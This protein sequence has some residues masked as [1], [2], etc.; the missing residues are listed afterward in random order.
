[1]VVGA[2]H[3]K[4]ISILLEDENKINLSS[5][6]NIPASSSIVKFIG[7]S[8][9][10]IIIGSLFYIGFTK[11]IQTVGDN[12]VFWI[13]A[14]GILSALGTLIAK[15]HIIT[16]AAAFFAA[17]FTSLTPVI[18]AGYVA[19]FVQMYVAPPIVKEFE[20]V[21]TDMKKLKSW[22]KN[23]LLRILLVFL[24]CGIGSI[25]GTYIGAYEI[26]LNLF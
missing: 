23:K 11:G 26:I 17:P 18:G 6:E 21:N 7:W 14:N 22:W 16:I 19:A 20:S 1:A 15:G 3:V 12:I 9:P 25:L 10:L 2:G 24:F 8:V 13:L 5:L 4:G